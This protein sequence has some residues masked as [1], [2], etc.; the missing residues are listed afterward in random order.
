MVEPFAISV[1]EVLR[2]AVEGFTIL[3]GGSILM[4]RIGRLMEKFEQIANMQTRELAELKNEMVQM[5]GAVM[6]IAV[7]D[8]RISTLASRVDTFDKRLYDLSHGEG[9][10]TGLRDR[11]IHAGE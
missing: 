8:Q 9:F 10:V 4:L 3:G 1:A 5:R 2:W 6:Q 11:V 7:Q